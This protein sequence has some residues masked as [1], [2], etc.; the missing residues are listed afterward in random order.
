MSLDIQKDSTDNSTTKEFSLQRFNLPFEPDYPSGFSE[1]PGDLA[2]CLEFILPQDRSARLTKKPYSDGFID[3]TSTGFQMMT[4]VNVTLK[5]LHDLLQNVQLE[6]KV[7]GGFSA[8]LF[9]RLEVVGAPNYQGLVGYTTTT[10]FLTNA[11][12]LRSS[13]GYWQNNNLIDT[14]Q[15][16][17]FFQQNPTLIPLDRATYKD[18]EIPLTFP[19]DKFPTPNS[20]SIPDALMQYPM[21]TFALYNIVPMKTVSTNTKVY[22]AFRLYLADV[23][24]DT[25]RLPK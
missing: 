12:R 2:P 7:Y 8:R 19:L 13:F 6:T 16:R 14:S 23:S 22:Y 20:P 18:I 3:Q 11:Y 5:T 25:P 9:C 15:S 17:R 10:G 1:N 4:G 21:A 24:F